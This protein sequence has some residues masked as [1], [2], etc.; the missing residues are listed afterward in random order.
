MQIEID[1][2]GKETCHN[3]NKIIETS[4][5]SLNKNCIWTNAWEPNKCMYFASVLL[6]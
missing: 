6:E 5:N 3:N 2:I 1:N 4:R